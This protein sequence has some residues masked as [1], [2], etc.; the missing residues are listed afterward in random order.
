MAA[1]LVP[2]LILVNSTPD[3][4]PADVLMAVDEHEKEKK[5]MDNTVEGSKA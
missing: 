4:I 2:T 3:E 1:A 5:P